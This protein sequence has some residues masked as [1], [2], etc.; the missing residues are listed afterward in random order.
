MTQHALL[1]RQITMYPNFMDDALPVAVLMSLLT[2]TT[3]ALYVL[4]LV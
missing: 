4:E 1:A 2:L 3:N